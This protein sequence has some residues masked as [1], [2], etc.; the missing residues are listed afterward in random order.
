MDVTKL[1]EEELSYELRARG[2][3]AMNDVN[4]MRSVLRGL[5]RIEVE[6]NSLMSADS[7]VPGVNV[8]SE[9][10]TCVKKLQVINEMI[11]NIQGDRYSEQYRLADA[12]LCHLMNRVDKLPA[13][14]K[15]D[16][17]D[18]SNLL[19][20]ILFLMRK[21][22]GM[23]SNTSVVETNTNQ[24]DGAAGAGTVVLYEKT[25]TTEMNSTYGSAESTAS[26]EEEYF[27]Q[28][29]VAIKS[30]S[31][32]HK[33]SKSHKNA[34]THYTGLLRI[35]KYR[36]AKF[37]EWKPTEMSIFPDVDE[38]NIVDTGY[39]QNGK[40]KNDRSNIDIK[41]NLAT[42][43]SYKMKKHKKHQIS[44]LQTN[45]SL[46][47]FLFESS[48]ISDFVTALKTL[49]HTEKEI[50]H[51]RPT[52]VILV[53]GERQDSDPLC[54]SIKELKIFPD[55]PPT[56]TVW[57]FISGFQNNPVEK[58]YETFAK[59]SD[60][61]L[62]RTPDTRPDQEVAE[63]LNRAEEDDEYTMVD[64]PPPTVLPPRPGIKPRGNPLDQTTFYQSMNDEGRITNE[65]YIKNII[66]YGGCEHSIRHE[67]WKYLLGYYPW[68]S[69]REQRI[70]IDKQQKTEY[71]RMKV[72]WMNMSS[73]Q[74]SRFNMYRDRKSLIDKDVYRTDRTLDFY[75]GEGNEN[76]VKLHNVLMTYVMYNFDLG[77]VQGMSDLLSP[78]LMIMNSDEV[79]SFWC[80][81]G[82]MNR[83]NTNFELKQTGMKKQLND[84]HYLLTTVS[85]KL[86]NHLKKM[87]SS[88]MYFCFR[89]LL[90]L[91]K[92]EFIYSDIMRLWEVLWTDIPCANFH[93][94]ICVAI[95]DNEKDTIINENYGLTEILKHVNNL[96]EQIDLDKALTTA[97]SIYEQLKQ[98]QPSLQD[99]VN[100][101]LGFS[102]SHSETILSSDSN[103]REDD[104]E[105]AL[106]MNYT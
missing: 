37:I 7:K 103:S 80:F 105:K 8:K 52:G 6:G 75:A 22:E 56:S 98:A 78:I 88:N 81:V 10:K 95:L 39:K 66:F 11:D 1:D 83:V 40:N 77:Y 26:D 72:Q 38:W 99:S 48:P 69:T 41:I 96:C 82:F 79:E 92:R 44:I 49:L 46:V 89:W 94:L 47:T 90:V 91:F 101:L 61:L 18:R 70:N 71:E 100:E 104:Y 32:L 86:E 20:G 76:L 84:L 27:V 12:K 57:S 9:V 97:Y 106:S 87:D 54:Q 4:E 102:I 67:V 55:Q 28:Q 2:I 25:T 53:L 73:D 62:T 64:H 93:L 58:T 17:N 3:A 16:Q 63:L 24:N 33:G 35:M 85:P 29:G 43:K 51:H 60:V 31:K 50:R 74:I 59:I 68:D 5:L 36:T 42:M 30:L 65:D 34:E 23:A 19:K 45:G 21:M 14:E 13:V 15:R